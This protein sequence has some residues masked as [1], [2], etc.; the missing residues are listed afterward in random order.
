M[1]NQMFAELEIDVNKMVGMGNMLR[2]LNIDFDDLV[3]FG[4]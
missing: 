2:E 4:R 3:R 1:N